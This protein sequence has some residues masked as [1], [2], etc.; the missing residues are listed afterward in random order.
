MTM[1]RKVMGFDVVQMKC[2]GNAWES[3]KSF[4]ELPESLI[5]IDVAFGGFEMDVIHGVKT[6]QS[7]VEGNI[8]KRGR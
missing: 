4:K 3:V 8:S 7:G 2:F 1:A 6:Y 5:F